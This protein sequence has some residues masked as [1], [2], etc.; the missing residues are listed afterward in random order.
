MQTEFMEN[1]GWCPKKQ[2]MVP[3]IYAGDFEDVAFGIAREKSV[4]NP[5]TGEVLSKEEGHDGMKLADFVALE[6][7]QKA[8]LKPA[9][10]LTW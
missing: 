4:E 7:A 10:E 6:I 5:A 8:K 1:E 2:C 3:G 9:H